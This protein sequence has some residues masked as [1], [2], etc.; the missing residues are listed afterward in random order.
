ML[1]RNAIETDI[2]AQEAAYDLRSLLTGAGIGQC[3]TWPGDNLCASK[4]RGELDSGAGYRPTEPGDLLLKP[5]LTIAADRLQL[6][7]P[8]AGFLGGQAQ[9]LTSSED[10]HI[11]VPAQRTR[12]T[13]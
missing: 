8:A 9:R 5:Q 11:E 4:D 12:S 6:I 7:C 3:A 10:A 2:L 1:G 13:G